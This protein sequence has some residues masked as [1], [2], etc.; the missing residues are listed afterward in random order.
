M[1]QLS[2]H[3]GGILELAAELLPLLEKHYE[4]ITLNKDVVTLAP[5]WGRYADI[6]AAGKFY[7]FLLRDEGK[8]VG[9]SAF[10]LDTHLHYSD[11]LVASNDVLYIDPA[12]RKTGDGA[13]LIKFSESCLSAMGA[14]KITWHV[15][16]NKTINGVEQLLDFRPLLHRS[17]YADEETLVGKII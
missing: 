9:Y 13:T 8:L 1:T 14:Q 3:T 12:Y 16:F 15:K 6:E 17:G 7:I 10:F 4:E 11:L 5:D 2:V